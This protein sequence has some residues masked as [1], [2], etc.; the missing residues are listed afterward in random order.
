VIVGVD[1]NSVPC[2][3]PYHI[4]SAGLQDAFKLNGWGLGTTMDSLPA[5]LR[6]DFL[7]VD[8]KLEIK[9]YR[10][11][12]VNLSDHFPQFVDVAWKQE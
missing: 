2:S 8:N 6:I 5:T 3:Y 12:E 7:F 10:K 4:V 1:M 9:R 11:D